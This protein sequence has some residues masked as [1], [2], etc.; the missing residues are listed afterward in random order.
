MSLPDVHDSLRQ[1]IRKAEEFSSLSII[2]N[3]RQSRI[4]FDLSGVQFQFQEFTANDE[5]VELINAHNSRVSRWNGTKT[6][7]FSVEILQAALK[8]CITD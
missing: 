4:I 5:I 2:Y 1:I 3:E 8:Y 7:L 6:F